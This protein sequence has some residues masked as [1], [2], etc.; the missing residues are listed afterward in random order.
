MAHS[1]Y[2]LQV[3]FDGQ[4]QGVGF[5]YKTVE[6]A[7]GYDVAGTVENL[8][9]GRVR[10]SAVGDKAQVREFV[11]DV[12]KVMADFIRNKTER[13]DYVESSPKGFSMLM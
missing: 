2:R 1:K 5:R 3:W 9:D 11:D 7:K 12:S 4:V 13:E 6:I 8:D 10:L